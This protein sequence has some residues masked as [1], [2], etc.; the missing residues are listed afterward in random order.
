[1]WCKV[2]EGYYGQITTTTA[3]PMPEGMFIA[4]VIPDD[5]LGRHARAADLH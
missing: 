1:M 5:K 2:P 4:P 3:Q